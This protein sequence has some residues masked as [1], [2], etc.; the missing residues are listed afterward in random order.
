MFSYR[1]IGSLTLILAASIFYGCTAGAPIKIDA[2][3]S[4]P[5][6]RFYPGSYSRDLDSRTVA[7]EALRN[8]T[9]SAQ[10][11]VLSSADGVRLSTRVGEL[12]GPGSFPASNVR[13]RY[14]DYVL[15]DEIE[16][17]VSDP[18]MET[19]EVALQ[20]HRAQGVWFTI[21]V[22]KDCKP[23]DYS[24]AVDLQADGKVVHTFTL[25]LTVIDATLPDPAD[26]RFF[27]NI[28]QDAFSI[29]RYYKVPLW[30]EEHFALISRY[31]EDLALHGQ[32]SV[33]TSIVTNAW[34]DNDLEFNRLPTMIEWQYP[35]EWNQPDGQHFSFDFAVFDRYVEIFTKL[36]IKREITCLS[37]VI[38]PGASP[39][40][41]ITYKDT[42][43]GTLKTRTVQVG[44]PLYTQAWSDFAREFEKHLREKGWLSI[45]YLLL[46]EKP[47]AIVEE[48]RRVFNAAAPGLQLNIS[49][50]SGP[51]GEQNKL[52]SPQWVLIYGELL[53]PAV[54]AA[55][56][57]EERRAR[58]QLT[59]FYTACGEDHPNTFVYSPLR[60]SRM[61]PWVAARYNVD[62]YIRWAWNLWP[63]D[64]W[65]QARFTWPTGDMF[66][67]YPGEKG[68][69]DSTRWELLHQGIEDVEAMRLLKER[70][71][72]SPKEAEIQPELQ[73]LM[74]NATRVHGC[75][76]VKPIGTAV[77]SRIN[78]LLA[79]NPE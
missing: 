54:A 61:L 12:S 31:A 15:V 18:L 69:I 49:G 52:E 3:V 8:E 56:T 36:G 2:W 44:T 59:L 41:E 1:S 50:S 30:S 48:V 73:R 35:G 45:T 38:G 58:G 67:V 60:E 74:R 65:K 42:K 37:P 78:Q 57:A 40:S 76:G 10:L 39:D 66:F 21:K 32:Q 51:M 28:L 72:G 79:E 68:P 27:L 71:A 4:S 7:V 20:A 16:G 55:Q 43:D 75:N 9:V 5:E 22:P 63:E 64:V 77:R 62:G 13:V 53:D 14:P 17:Y 29:A 34:R 46:D 33:T 47:S 23:G 26:Y 6:T 25:K 11:G 24:A 70:L 19:P